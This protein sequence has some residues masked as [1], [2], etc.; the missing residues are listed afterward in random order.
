MAL[1]CPIQPRRTGQQSGAA[2]V[3]IW[4]CVTCISLF[5][6]TLALADGPKQTVSAI[7]ARSATLVEKIGVVGTIVAREETLINADVDGLKIEA[8]LEEAGDRVTRGQLLATL[9][10][11]KIEADQLRNDAQTQNAE[12]LVGQARAAILGAAVTR[13]EADVDLQR[14]LKLS[15]RGLVATE[16]VEQ[17]RN[18]LSRA[19][20][21]LDS[22][23][24]SLKV[25]EA[26]VLTADAE[27][28][29]IAVRRSRTRIIATTDGKIISRNAKVGAMTSASGGPLFV[30]ANAGTVELEAEV[31]Q[32]QLFRLKVG[33][34]AAVSVG[35]DLPPLNGHVRLVA[36]SLTG[37][38]RLGRLRI[39]LPDGLDMPI[40]AF[41]KAD[42]DA[43]TSSGVFLPS[44]AIVDAPGGAQVQ[45]IRQNRV[46]SRAVET[47][48]RT[49]GVVEIRAGITPGDVVVLRAASFL[50]A[51][52]V[53][54]AYQVSYETD[55][56]RANTVTVVGSVR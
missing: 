46:E 11:A 44:S 19:Q 24:Q 32:S 35:M 29:D 40:G 15:A 38:T 18:S 2:H 43:A 13:E 47:G 12:A 51:G 8:I 41:A 7:V 42:L 4:S 39:T 34:T 28:H 53:V 30:I 33:A 1:S 5:S 49:G 56:A 45:V 17:R 3:C 25:A 27:R 20:A 6:Q 31:P 54:A 52:D 10:S 36:P 21:N 37:E 50:A 23:Q 16:A 9:D 26:A 48:L 22:A 55:Q 14:S